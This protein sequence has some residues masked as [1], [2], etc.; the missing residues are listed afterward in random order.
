MDKLTEKYLA[1]AS[2]YLTRHSDEIAAAQRF[3]GLPLDDVIC[4]A[5]KELFRKR[6]VDGQQREL[7]GQAEGK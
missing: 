7:F 4:L 2:D 6:A 1:A 3:L 5:I